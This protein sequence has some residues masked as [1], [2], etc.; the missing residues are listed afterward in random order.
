[1]VK[2]RAITYVD[3]FNL[4]YG[5]RDAKLGS[6]RWLNLTGVCSALLRP[7]QRLELVRYFTARVRG[8]PTAQG[9]QAIYIDALRELGGIEIEFGQFLL[10]SVRCHQCNYT[11]SKPEEKRTDVNIAVRMLEDAS[12]DRCDIALVVSGD[13]DLVPPIL[14]IR[15]RYPKKRVI[16][17]AP[18]RRWGAQITQAADAAIQIRRATIRA[19]RLPDPVI[20]RSGIALRAPSGWLPS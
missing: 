9:R 10:N 1:M 2:Q 5:L 11:W 20:T 19:N 4:Y 6:S 12:D 15:Q 13:S 14:S 8:D 16:V 7:D 3:G 18:P 17:A